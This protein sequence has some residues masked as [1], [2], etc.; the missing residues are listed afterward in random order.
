MILSQSSNFDIKFDIHT[1]FNKNHNIFFVVINTRFV[2]KLILIFVKLHNI[3][4]QKIDD[5]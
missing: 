5:N 3:I 2:I 1:M 4:T